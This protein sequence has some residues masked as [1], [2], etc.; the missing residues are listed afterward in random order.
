MLYTFSPRFFIFYIHRWLNAANITPHG[1]DDGSGEPKHYC[2]DF[3]INLSFHLDCLV[4]NFSLHVVGLQSIIYFHSVLLTNKIQI[5]SYTPIFHMD[6]IKMIRR[7]KDLLITSHSF[8]N[9]MTFQT[10]CIQENVIPTSIS[11]VLRPSQHIFPDYIRLYLESSVREI[12]FSEAHTFERGTYIWLWGLELRRKQGMSHKKADQLRFE[13]SKI[14]NNHISKLRS[15]FISLCNK[16]CWKNLGWADLVNN[17]SSSSL[18]P[19]ET[20]AISFGLKF[21]T[22]IKNHDMGKLINTNYKHHYSDFHKGFLQSIIATS[23]ELTLPNRYIT[24]L[25][26]LSSNHNI[27]ISPSDKGGAIVIMDSTVYNQKLMDLLGD[28][29]YEQ[30]SLQTIT[31]DITD[32]NKSYRKLISNEDKSSSSLINYHPTIPKIYGLPK[33]HKP[34]IPKTYYFWHRICPS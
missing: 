20:K 17:I 6:D 3:S 13:I 7:Y 16:S 34:N 24:A 25:K 4:I 11:S 30:I 26:T 9:R 22:G 14:N 29:S 12:K 15:K 19:I 1:P 18:S 10:N 28:N 33:T 5:H 2:V 31:N 27:V 21:A 8:K 23:D 32:F